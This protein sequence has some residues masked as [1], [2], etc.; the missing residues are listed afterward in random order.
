ML[1]SSKNS[2]P[3]L[4]RAFSE[5]VEEIDHGSEVGIEEL[6]KAELL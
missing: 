6:I 3:E 5:A 4:G 2:E 1:I